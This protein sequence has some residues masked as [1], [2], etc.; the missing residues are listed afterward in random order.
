MLLIQIPDNTTIADTVTEVF[1][2]MSHKTPPLSAFDRLIQWLLFQLMRLLNLLHGNSAL[3]TAVR[4]GIWTAVVLAILWVVWS[5]IIQ[6]EDRSSVAKFQRH[7]VQ[8]YW[9]VAQQLADQGQYTEAAHALY[10]GLLYTI[11]QRRYVVVHDSKTIGD[12]VREVRKKAPPP[13]IALF[14]DFARSY[15][16]VVYRLEICDA[17]RYAHLH[18]LAVQ[19][20]QHVSA[21]PSTAKSAA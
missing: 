16:V 10:T 8:D 7:R 14:T 6:S 9:Q 17:E 18:D 20:N 21:K 13:M 19:M 11:A 2:A 3:N 1:R 12:Y 5:F 4:V 15:E